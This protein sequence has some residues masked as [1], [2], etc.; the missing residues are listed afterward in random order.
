MKVSDEDQRPRYVQVADDLRR[1]VTIGILKAGEQLPATRE[2]AEQYGVAPM[3]AQKAI[4]LLKSE[5]IVY[6]AVGRGTFVRTSAQ[7]DGAEP[8]SEFSALI[9][10][11]EQLRASVREQMSQLDQRLTELEEEVRRPRRQDS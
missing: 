4:D 5:G 1:S 10:Q 3:T 7:D 11:V 6:S 8:S 2:L 9:T